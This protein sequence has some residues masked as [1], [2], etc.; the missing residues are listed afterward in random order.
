MDGAPQG[1]G[2][3]SWDGTR[4]LRWNGQT[5]IDE[6]NGKPVGREAVLVAAI[7]T[8]FHAVAALNQWRT[9]SSWLR[10]VGGRGIAIIATVSATGL[11]V[12][13][14]VVGSASSSTTTTTTSSPAPSTTTSSA[15][16]G[17]VANTSVS[18][19]LKQNLWSNRDAYDATFALMVPLHTAFGTPNNDELA[20]D[21]SAFFARF[22][23]HP[24]ALTSKTLDRIQFTY[25]VSRYG[26]LQSS[27][28]GCTD[29]TRQVRAWLD[30]ELTR[31][32]AS[33]VAVERAIIPKRTGPNK[34]AI[35][36][37]R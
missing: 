18:A 1:V 30:P 17:P 11:L 2:D 19:L 10:R 4:W 16:S 6:S 14:G 28:D 32:L 36:T 15:S 8:R 21:F 22:L 20:S 31:F 37:G 34:M 9:M 29:T 25:L 24:S 7:A 27:K 12:V 3:R 33:C 23:A 5:W 26:V 13:V 35:V